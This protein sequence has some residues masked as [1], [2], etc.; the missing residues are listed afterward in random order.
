M[1]TLP[2]WASLEVTVMVA[3]S[4]STSSNIAWDEYPR[5]HTTLDAIDRSAIDYFLKKGIASGRIEADERESSTEQVLRNLNL[6]DE[7]GRLK[8]A[9][10]LLFAAQP[11]KYFSGVEFKIGKF[12]RNEAE[13]IVQDVVEGNLIEMTDK[14]V[15]LLKTYYLKSYIHYENLQRIETLE[16]PEEALREVIYNAVAHK[17]YTGAPI[18]MRIYDDHVEL[19]NDGELPAGYTQ[20]T[21]MRKHYS[22]PRNKNIAFAFFKAGYVEAWGRGYKKIA[23][24]LET[25]HLPMPTVTNDCGGTLV[26]IMRPTDNPYKDASQPRNVGKETGNVGKDFGKEIWSELTERQLNIIAYITLDPTI[27][28]V[29]ISEKMSGKNAVSA[30]TIERDLAF[31]QARGLLSRV[32]GRKEGHWEI[33]LRQAPQPPQER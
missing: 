28:A 1:L 31:L 24:A 15:K 10:L 26:S 19:W 16:I 22:K 13:L 25:A 5:E 33:L 8:N 4:L 18:Q 3:V 11:Q 29:G 30:R 6:I 21:L 12:G 9:A 23:E 20:E 32:G 7:D 17:D 2:F 14:V 27:T